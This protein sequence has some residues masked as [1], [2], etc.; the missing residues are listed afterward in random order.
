V[1]Y[2]GASTFAV[3]G[4]TVFNGNSASIDASDIYIEKQD[5]PLSYDM[6]FSV[7]SSTFSN[8]T[9]ES[10]AGSI[11]I[12]GSFTQSCD[13]TSCEFS[14]YKSAFGLFRTAF[15]QGIISIKSTTIKACTA[16]KTTSGLSG[17][18]V[19]YADHAASEA[20]KT[21]G[22]NASKIEFL[23]STI[24]ENSAVGY[25]LINLVNQGDIIITESEF[26]NNSH[27]VL[28]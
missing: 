12:S 6:D 3:T 14:G 25:A 13:V 26:L 16:V 9:C 27:T 19:L 8:G 20:R 2:Y 5:S 18:S 24:Q 28:Y 22:Q 4:S 11:Y 7:S 23:K 15:T 1:K 21:S 10:G 17:V